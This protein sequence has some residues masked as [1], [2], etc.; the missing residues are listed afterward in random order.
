MLTAG[1]NALII[2]SLVVA[3]V[4]LIVVVV[5]VVVVLIVVVVVVVAT[6]AAAAVASPATRTA[7][8]RRRRRRLP[9]DTPSALRRPFVAIPA[10]PERNF[11]P[12][13][14]SAKTA[15]RGRVR[16]PDPTR[17]AR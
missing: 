17:P 3:V 4:V 2:I 6:A 5:V 11:S 13:S 14:R 12:Q 10:P 7:A 15:S 8:G 1:K 16:P 9:S